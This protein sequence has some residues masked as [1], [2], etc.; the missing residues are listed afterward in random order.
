MS[1]IRSIN[2]RIVCLIFGHK[3]TSWQKV[4]ADLIKRH[5]TQCDRV[6]RIDMRNWTQRFPCIKN[7]DGE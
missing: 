2:S 7:N 4:T 3:M 5:C 1:L 6:E